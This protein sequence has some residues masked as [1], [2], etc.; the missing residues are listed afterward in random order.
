MSFAIASELAAG[1]VCHVSG[2]SMSTGA[3]V[4][5][6]TLGAGRNQE[7]YL[8]ALK[9]GDD[10][11]VYAIQASHSNLYAE[12]ANRSLDQRALIV[13]AA[14]V[15]WDPAQQWRLEPFGDGTF[16]IRSVLSGLVWDIEEATVTPG[17]RLIQWQGHGGRNQ[18]WRFT[19][20]DH[21][22]EAPGSAEA[23]HITH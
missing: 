16:A 3:G 11:Y 21:L 20:K 5:T 10:P 1:L 6:A 7:W 13:Q 2:A 18:R 23:P 14:F 8:R 4:Q 12:V 22:A 15:R 9:L 17:T 19:V